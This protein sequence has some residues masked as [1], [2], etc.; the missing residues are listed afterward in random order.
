MSKLQTVYLFA[1][2]F[3]IL[4]IAPFVFPSIA[5]IALFGLICLFVAI[6]LYTAIFS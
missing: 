5:A 6:V 2:I 1:A 3:V 4:L